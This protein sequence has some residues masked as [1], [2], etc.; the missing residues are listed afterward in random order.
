VVPSKDGK[1]DMFKMPQLYLFKT[2]NHSVCS[3]NHVGEDRIWTFPKILIRL[4]ISLNFHILSS[5]PDYLPLF[6]DVSVHF[7]VRYPAIP[8]GSLT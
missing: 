7:L 2:T 8:S 1:S 4:G 5:H 6:D 3:Y